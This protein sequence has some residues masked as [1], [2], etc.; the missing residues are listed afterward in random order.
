MSRCE[1]CG[2]LIESAY[3]DEWG[4][5]G[6]EV[7]S[8][9]EC[10]GDIPTCDCCDEPCDELQTSSLGDECCPECLAEEVQE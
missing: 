3:D 4:S 7:C 8:N 10:P 5:F 9:D 1:Y 2:A 6:P